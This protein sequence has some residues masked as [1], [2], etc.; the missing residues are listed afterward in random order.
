MKALLIKELKFDK[1]TDELIYQLHNDKDVL[2]RLWAMNELATREKTDEAEK[3]KILTALNQ[4]ITGD[5][6]WAIRRDTI[7]A[8]ANVTVSRR[9][10]T[11]A[12][13][14]DLDPATLNALATAAKDKNSLVRAAAIEVL[15]AT[16]NAKYADI[17][18]TALNDQSYAV[19]D[20]AAVALANTKDNRAYDALNKLV[21]ADSWKDRVRLAGLN[22]LSALGDKRALDAG[23]KIPPDSMPTPSAPTR[24]AF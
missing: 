3:A 10:Q 1:P 13:P 5:A 9:R 16:K 7:R 2:G 6:F 24:S 19:I 8:L 22:G 4:T 14:T 20:A 15:G 23:F 21:N 17:Y 12:P 11:V 18:A